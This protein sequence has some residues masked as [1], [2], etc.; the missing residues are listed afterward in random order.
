[1]KNIPLLC[2]VAAFFVLQFYVFLV[3]VYAATCLAD[4]GGGN[5]VTCSG[6]SCDATDGEGCRAYDENGRLTVE[7]RCVPP[8]PE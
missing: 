4:C 7:G 6:H 5:V 1:M 2:L 3:P 8:V